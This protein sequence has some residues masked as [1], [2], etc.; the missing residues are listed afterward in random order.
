MLHCGID[1]LDEFM[2]WSMH[3]RFSL[4]DK[5]EMKDRTSSSALISAIGWRIIIFIFFK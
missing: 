5:R 1:R 4:N 3:V 2:G